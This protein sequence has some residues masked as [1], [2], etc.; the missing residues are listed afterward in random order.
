[1]FA[2]A[3]IMEWAQHAENRDVIP[4]YYEEKIDLEVEKANWNGSTR[5][6]DHH[7]TLPR[8]MLGE[9]L[10]RSFGRGE[11]GT[12][13]RY[14]SAGA[15]YPVIPLLYI[16]SRDSVE[17]ID[18]P[19]CYLFESSE[20]SLLCLKKWD[21]KDLSFATA[22]INVGEEILSPLAIGYAVDL[23]RAVA[24]YRLKGY[25]HALIEI[26]LMAQ[27]FRETLREMD[28][29]LGEV[30]WSGFQENALTYY[31]GLNVRLAP[32][33]LVQWFGKKRSS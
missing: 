6:F 25:R 24:K 26:G 11:T 9:L 28:E 2:D 30:C 4:S 20:P 14:P 22:A 33:T 19:G 21:D 32:V 12:S 15:L 1:M 5:E 31:S 7:W 16:L 8:K 29:E 27:S 18:S 3:A 23:R 13:K 10:Y 17:G